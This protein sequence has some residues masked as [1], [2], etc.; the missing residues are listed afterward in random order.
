MTLTLFLHLDG[1]PGDSRERGHEKW[2]EVRSVVWGLTAHSTTYRS[3]GG[4]GGT[5]AGPVTV[6][7]AAFTAPMGSASPLLMVACA[8][9][10]HIH[11]ARFE[12]RKD[13]QTPVT[14]ARLDFEE[15]RISAYSF[16]GTD[17]DPTLLDAFELTARRIR[18]T[19]VSSSLHGGA[20]VS[21]DRGWDFTAQRAW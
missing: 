4:G 10:H 8:A 6:R 9:G 3:G 17:D 21:S 20:G 7:T 1:I 15:L 12:V 5:V 14:V 11:A 16:A 18:E 2:I 13:G 19:T